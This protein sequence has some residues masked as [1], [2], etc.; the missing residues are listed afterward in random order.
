MG[1]A[2]GLNDCLQ[3]PKMQAEFYPLKVDI[4][5]KNEIPTDFYIIV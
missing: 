2:L 3:V 4:I 5:L 1:I